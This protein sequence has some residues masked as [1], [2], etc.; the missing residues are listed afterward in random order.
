MFRVSAAVGR[1]KRVTCAQYKPARAALKSTLPGA[2]RDAFCISLM[3][4]GSSPSC[5]SANAAL[6]E[7]TMAPACGSPSRWL[8]LMRSQA[9]TETQHVLQVLPSKSMQCLLSKH[10]CNP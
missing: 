6:D 8:K 9:F 1:R 5:T 4:A 3:A 2:L 10:H 7:A